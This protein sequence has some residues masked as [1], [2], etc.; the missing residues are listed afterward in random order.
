MFAFLRDQLPV[1]W[2]S[3]LFPIF[4]FARDACGRFD[5]SIDRRTLSHAALIE[6]LRD[7]GFNPGATVMVHSSFSHI[8]RR[9]PDITPQRLIALVQELLGPEGTLL[10]PTFPFQGSQG[11]YADR[12]PRFDVRKTPS[13]VGVLTEAFRQTRGVVRSKHPTHPVGAWGRHAHEII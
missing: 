10:M 7:L 2:H 1:R 9:V 13:K 3:R 12:T 8:R 11:E 5:R 4:D 6:L